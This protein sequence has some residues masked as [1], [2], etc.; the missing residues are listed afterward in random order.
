MSLYVSQGLGEN[1]VT[2]S[3]VAADRPRLSTFID[4]SVFYKLVDKSE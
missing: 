1:F 4:L 3:P 2:S